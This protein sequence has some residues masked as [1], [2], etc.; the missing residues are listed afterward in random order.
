[1][2]DSALDAILEWEDSFGTIVT[3]HDRDFS[4][5]KANESARRLLHIAPGAGVKCFQAY[6]GHERPPAGCPSCQCLITGTA[7]SFE[8]FEPHLGRFFRFE[9]LP[10]L[11]PDGKVEFLVHAARD[12]TSRKRL[13][14]Q[15]LASL[16]EK[17]LLLAEIHHR[18]RNNL[19]VMHGLLELQAAHA[20]DGRV[21]D[22]MR[23]CQGRILS[24]GRIHERLYSGRDV[25]DVRMDE[26]VADL[27]HSLIESYGAAGRVA[28]RLD[29]T[30][31]PL[32]I[33]TA[34]PCGLILNELLTNAL[35]HAFPGDRSGEIQVAFRRGAD[36][37]C[38][39]VVSDDGIGLP[40]KVDVR[41]TT[42]FGLKL[43]VAFGEGE[44]GGTIEVIR[45]RGTTIRLRF[46]PAAA[47]APSLR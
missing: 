3:V 13:E 45:A 17:D 36:D 32:G 14:E 43:V 27:A 12:I 11:G 4:V 35:R 10:L 26:F 22:A 15:I 28:V 7:A 42:S 34:M 44:L 23:S 19:Q 47:G 29:V 30:D 8:S 5:V 2:Q 24:M 40:K 18:V 46:A 16:R 37:R 25:P 39:L 21:A 31:E 1:M 38:E 9:A 33:T 41:K 20:T 6:H